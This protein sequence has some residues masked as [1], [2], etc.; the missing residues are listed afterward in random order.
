MGQAI[1]YIREEP[2]GRYNDNA[3]QIDLDLDSNILLGGYDDENA[4]EYEKMSAVDALAK[5]IN[6]F[7][8]VDIRWIADK[9]GMQVDDAAR[10]LRGLIYL[11]PHAWSGNIEDGWE[12]A[13]Q[14][15]SGN[16]RLKLTHARI[17]NK[18]YH[19]LFDDNIRALKRVLPDE[20]TSD[21]VRVPLGSP[22][23]TPEII[24]DFINYAFGL[25]PY[26]SYSGTLFDELTGSWELPNKSLFAENIRATSTYG[27]KDR[28]GIILLEDALNHR[29][30]NVTEEVSSRD[31]KSGTRRVTNP[32]KTAAA[33]EKR[34]LLCKDFEEWEW[35]DP[36]REY[37][38][39]NKY[40]S[41]YRRNVARRFDGSILEFPGLSQDVE[42]FPYVKDNA[43]AIIF[44]EGCFLLAMD[45]GAGKTYVM[46]M[47]GMELIRLGR[48]KKIMYVVPNHLVGQ[49]RDIF[50][51]LYKDAFIR[52]VEPDDFTPDRIAETLLDIKEND[53]DGIIIASSCFDRIPLSRD[54]SISAQK[55]ELDRLYRIR[56]KKKKTTAR[57]RNKI[58]KASK[59]LGD[60]AVS[61]DPANSITCFD[62]LGIDRLYIDEAHTYK[63]LPIETTIKGVY[64]I[65]TA[66]NEK[67]TNML[68]KVRFIQNR[69]SGG[70]VVM[71]TG[72]PIT[73]SI[74]DLFVFQKYLQNG[75]LELTNISSFD[76][77]VGMFAEEQRN[78]EIAVDTNTFRHASRFSAFHNLPDLTSML[79][80]I[81]LFHHL[82]QSDDIPAFTG[83]KDIMVPQSFDLRQF[84]EEL[85]R[86]ADDVHSHRVARDEDN[87]LK[88]TIDGRL[89]ALDIR[90]VKDIGDPGMTKVSECA[91]RVALIYFR[92]MARL[93]TQIVF[94]DSST[95]KKGFNVYDELKRLLV[96]YGVKEEDIAFIHDAGTS[97]KRDKLFRDF[98]EGKIRVLIGSTSKLG[99]GVNIQNKVKAL[100]HLDIPWRPSDWIQREARAFRVGNENEEVDVYRY[101]TRGSFDS[102]S[103]QLLETKQNV[104]DNLLSGFAVDRSCK[105][106]SDAVLS[107]AEVKALTIGNP[108]LKRAFE[109]RNDITWVK[110]LIRQNKENH[111]R[112]EIRRDALPDEITS[113]QF[114]YMDWA[115]EAEYAA[116][117]RRGTETDSKARI[118][119]E[120]SGERRELRERILRAV[121]SNVMKPVERK[122]VDYSG[123]EVFLPKDMD[124]D[125]PYVILRRQDAEDPHR[126]SHR[127][128]LSYKEKGVLVRIDNYIDGIGRRAEQIKLDL[129]TLKRE[130]REIDEELSQNII[131][132]YE[133]RLEDLNEEL[134]RIT[135][136]LGA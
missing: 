57:F 73:N 53:Y 67:C 102:Y 125:Y 77:W 10:A 17:A 48:A 107:F 82:D 134:D 40:S 122:L 90:L 37:L 94:C 86:R 123:Y 93:S 20:P 13:D 62:Q 11:N 84:L 126:V 54:S 99:L 8:R 88:I 131:G 110:S 16:V 113:K 70:G 105:D 95:P 26:M 80:S 128:N 15:L 74:T 83:Y 41:M 44:G 85:S 25:P 104:I 108:I 58:K 46:I 111:V 106:V 78:F 12:M 14:Y 23:L 91:E 96:F 120:E 132:V 97:A 133:G 114:E 92:T 109:V 31:T 4:P 89:A 6:H 9:S 21:E 22:V 61:Y 52:C 103:W 87:M 69:N 30:S 136:E 24:D 117:V 32:E 39:L 121:L 118:T 76:S 27:T 129:E 56:D 119:E 49:W 71:A 116:K 101:M 45:T 5:C 35:K 115:E 127:V 79:S 59:T 60:I 55:A 7:R 50:R 47:S 124:A 28:N 36:E 18:R 42:I 130:L 72:T 2:A 65:S 29:P 112:L 81:A 19:G 66:G 38:I 135:E 33:Y 100:H 75:A 51:K 64:G 3:S 98:R 68:E 43:A 1:N 34:M 63:N